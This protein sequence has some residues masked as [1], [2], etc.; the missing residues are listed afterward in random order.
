MF[1]GEEVRVD[2]RDIVPVGVEGPGRD[3][4][5]CGDTFRLAAVLVEEGLFPVG[6]RGGLVVAARN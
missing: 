5:F 3:T 2:V 4:C 1:G 6:L